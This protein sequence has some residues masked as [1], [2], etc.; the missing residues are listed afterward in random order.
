MHASLISEK[1][2]ALFQNYLRHLV[3]C[4]ISEYLAIF[5]LLILE[6]KEES[7]STFSEITL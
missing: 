7:H 5:N 4:I 1:C 3:P 2:M 6:G